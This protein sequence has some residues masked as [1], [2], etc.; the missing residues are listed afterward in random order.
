MLTCFIIYFIFV[1][2]SLLVLGY[3]PSGILD[4]YNKINKPI[5]VV[6]GR[7]LFAGS[8]VLAMLLILLLISLPFV[9]AFLILFFIIN[10]ITYVLFRI[11]R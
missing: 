10:I 7:H 5:E 2:I 11:V 9:I 6:K 3:N 8:M 1:F 4:V